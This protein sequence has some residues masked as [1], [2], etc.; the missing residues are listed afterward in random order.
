VIAA[1]SA[2][3][4]TGRYPR[5]MIEYVEDPPAQTAGIG[6]AFILVARLSMLRVLRASVSR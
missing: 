3:A 2:T 6:Y 4:F 1:C 5:G